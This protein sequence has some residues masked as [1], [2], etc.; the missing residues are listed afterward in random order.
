MSSEPI[1]IRATDLG[2]CY[3]V[4]D[5]P[6]DRLKQPIMTRLRR[7]QGRPEPRYYRE[8]WALRDVSLEL[9]RGETVGLI[10]RNGSGKST[11]LQILCG[12]L[13]PTTGQ[14]DTQGRI[15]ALLELGA[16][17]NP[18]FTGRENVYL[19][20]GVLG[21][22]PTEV[23][24]R[25]DRI[26]AFA[27]IG[28]FID[29]PVKTYSSGMFV[30]LAFA[31]AVNVDA[32]VLVVDEALAVGDM[33][34]QAKCMAHIQRLIDRGVSLLFVSHDV[35]AVK[36][37]CTRA[38]YLDQGRT[39]AI[40]ETAGVV[41]AYYS[42]RVQAE[43][44]DRAPSDAPAQMPAPEAFDPSDLA[45]QAEFAQRAGFQRIRNG[46]AEFLDVRLTDLDGHPLE[47][48]EFGQ[49][50]V[51]R[52]LLRANQ[53]IALAGMAYHLR[54]RTGY[55]V[56][57]SDT[58][59][60]SKPLLNLAAGQIIET[61]WRFTVHLREG[62]YSIAA[63][64]SIP[65]N[66]EIAQVDVCDFVPIAWTFKVMRGATLPLHGACYWPN[67]VVHRTLRNPDTETRA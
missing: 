52:M 9:R 58:A 23:D 33:Y 43:R 6:E 31:V 34:F 20:G 48:V 19:N 7:L 55:D 54:D 26:A 29:Q 63:M 44:A 62:D 2:K 27:D 14:V 39:Q 66:L 40:G 50:V 17:F 57:Y 35:G 49:T 64:L 59:I 32:D 1:L 28:A 3:Q 15:A 30:R 4:Y 65:E 51:L 42:A 11:L 22:T 25:F 61:D 56:V 12:T 46:Q 13:A 16:G 8:F 41:E 45:A 60:E 18:E 36:S 37:V 5:R 21:L 24:E 10:G 38:L 47:C 53:P 67:E